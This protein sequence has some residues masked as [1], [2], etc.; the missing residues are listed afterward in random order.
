MCRVRVPHNPHYPQRVDFNHVNVTQVWQ[1]VHDG[2]LETVML[3]PDHKQNHGNIHW[4]WASYVFVSVQRDRENVMS[5]YGDAE[6]YLGPDNIP[7]VTVDHFAHHVQ[8]R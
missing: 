5:G 1:S 8:K 3:L 2:Y 7:V 4:N 6:C